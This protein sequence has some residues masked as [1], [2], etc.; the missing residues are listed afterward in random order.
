M[1]EPLT[2]E[3]NGE[4]KTVMEFRSAAL[5][6]KSLELLVRVSGAEAPRVSVEVSEV[7]YSLSLDR[8][9]SEEEDDE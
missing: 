7:V 2:Y 8:D 1:G 4:R 6:G 3:E 5:L 9:L